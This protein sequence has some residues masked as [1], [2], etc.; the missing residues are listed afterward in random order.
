[1]HISGFCT[2]KAD[3][4]G[5]CS[6]QP[7]FVEEYPISSEKW[8]CE[9]FALERPELTPLQIKATGAVLSL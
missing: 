2:L 9:G 1:M 6:Q 4:G 7:R 8:I 3:Y 5:T